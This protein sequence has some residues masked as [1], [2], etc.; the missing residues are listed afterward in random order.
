MR[1]KLEAD[2]LGIFAAQ[3]E[4][5]AKCSLRFRCP[6]LCAIIKEIVV[7]RYENIEIEVCPMFLED[8]Y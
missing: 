5:C 8:N 1:V 7:M 2:G 3:D 6:L 4:L